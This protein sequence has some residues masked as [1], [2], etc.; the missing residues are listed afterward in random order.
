MLRNT[1]IFADFDQNA[2]AEESYS[3]PPT[4]MLRVHGDKHTI[5]VKEMMD[6]IADCSM[7][8]T[9]R[10]AAAFLDLYV[11]HENGLELE[12]TTVLTAEVR[13]HKLIFGANG[14][15]SSRES[16]RVINQEQITMYNVVKFLD[17]ATKKNS[18]VMDMP[19][20]RECAGNICPVSSI[21]F[22][23]MNDAYEFIVK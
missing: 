8:A 20:Y 12:E 19:V 14:Y 3:K 7:E 15:I 22:Q 2:A 11:N 10:D 5:T 1:R 13:K 4:F 9:F 23:Y 17:Y 18:H 21:S 6:F 16:E